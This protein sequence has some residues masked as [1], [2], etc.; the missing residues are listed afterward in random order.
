MKLEKVE[1]FWGVFVNLK[2][3]GKYDTFKEA[4]I[5]LIKIMKEK[6]K[7]KG[8]SIEEIESLCWIVAVDENNNSINNANPIFFYEARD[9]GLE[10]NWFE[11]IL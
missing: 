9:I 5:A 10:N 3:A 2:D 6:I 7:Q 11:G 8:I 1:S 4:C